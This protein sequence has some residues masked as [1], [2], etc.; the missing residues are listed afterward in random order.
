[1]DKKV[2]MQHAFLDKSPIPLEPIPKDMME[3]S[4]KE[5]H[6][7]TIYTERHDMIHAQTQIKKQELQKQINMENRQTER[8]R[9]IHSDQFKVAALQFEQLLG[10]MDHSHERFLQVM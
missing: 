5:W 9:E 3:E 6:N 2:K 7:P 1:M 10:S 8:Y 4:L